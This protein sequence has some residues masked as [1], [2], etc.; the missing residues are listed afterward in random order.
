MLSR[1]EY[2]SFHFLIISEMRPNFRPHSLIY[3][4]APFLIVMPALLLNAKLQSIL[5]TIFYQNVL[6]YLLLFAIAFI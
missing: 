4:T 2:T 1:L 6:A 5:H 3:F